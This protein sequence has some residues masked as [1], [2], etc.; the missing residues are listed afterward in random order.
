M[1]IGLKNIQILLSDY[2]NFLTKSDGVHCLTGWNK[3]FDSPTPYTSHLL[4]VCQY[5]QALKDFPFEPLM[6]LLCITPK[7]A[8]L[9]SIAKEFPSS[10]DILFVAH[11][12]PAEI[13]FLLQDYYNTQCGVGFFGQTLFDFL[14]FETGLEEAI[15]YAHHV[16]T[17]PIFVFDGNFNLIAATWDAIAQ[18]PGAENL[19]KNKRFTEDEFKLLNRNHIHERVKK[20]E[21]P[22]HAFNEVLGYDQLICSI[23]TQKNLGHIVVCAVE[24]PFYPIDTELLLILKKYIDQQMKK[25]Q[26]IRNS[27]G[28]NYEYF[29]KDILDGKIATGNTLHS[30]MTYVKNEFMGN[31][32]CF[33]V[34]T[35]RS[36]SAVNIFRIRNLFES[37]F[38]N[39]KTIIYNNQIIVIVSIPNDG[40]IPNEYLDTARQICF[41]NELFTGLSTCFK[42]ILELSSY[43]KQALRAIELGACDSQNPNLFFYEDY[44]LDH[45]KNI[46]LQKESGDVFCHPKMRILLD[47]DKEHNS[48]LAYTFYMY[49][50][51]ERN[52][53]AAAAAMDMH[54]T[55]IIYRFKKI[56]A[57]IG[58][59]FDSYKERYYMILSYEMNKTGPS[60]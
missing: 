45:V 12:K 18:M 5:T 23:N 42:D 19:L 34:E 3:L 36:A 49:L 58:D 21:L 39:S 55:S 2:K 41:E 56:N 28:F 59:N 44:Y 46:F 9:E 53:A 6:H 29:L 33:V 32:Y 37:R 4:Y 26:F 15:N 30:R 14:S 43:Y 54:R 60:A 35:A 16:L 7:D 24:H 38:P 22:I 8:D 1:Y 13:H 31:L 51:H 27:R 25:D 17:N 20:S 52:I 40:L 47:Y 10:M 48:E 50:I 11:D 57:L